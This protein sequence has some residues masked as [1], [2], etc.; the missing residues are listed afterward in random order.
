MSVRELSKKSP[1]GLSLYFK[2]IKN[3]KKQLFS[4]QKQLAN[5][6]LSDFRR[7]E[8]HSWV[9]FNSCIESSIQSLKTKEVNLQE[10][11]ISIDL[12]ALPIVFI[13]VLKIN[14]C[15]SS[16]LKTAFHSIDN[17]GHIH[18]SS[19]CN[20]GNILL[21]IK[22]NGAGLTSEK[23]NTLRDPLFRFH[24]Y[25]DSS[26]LELAFAQLIAKEHGGSLTV[27]SS[28][29]EGSTLTLALPIPAIKNI[30]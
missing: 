25:T 11:Q 3:V 6:E 14:Q 27:L 20:R 17:T 26:S 24:A 8:L 5:I 2:M 28:K 15:I 29:G 10:N 12:S 1:E 21:M 13:N 16:L 30:H 19:Q 9:D 22:D 23:I 4:A 18:V 7:T